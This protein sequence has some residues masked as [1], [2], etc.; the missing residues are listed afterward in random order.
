MFYIHLLLIRIY[1]D[2]YQPGVN[3]ILNTHIFSAN[4]NNASD[5]SVE[6]IKGDIQSKCK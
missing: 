3:K 4:C 5:Q 1:T 6:T 2:F